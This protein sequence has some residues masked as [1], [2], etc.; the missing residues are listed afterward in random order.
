VV[1]PLD[2][3][4]KEYEPSLRVDVVVATLRVPSEE[5][6]RSS[7]EGLQLEVMTE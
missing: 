4:C 3:S 7:F 5:G 2:E 6:A 1:I